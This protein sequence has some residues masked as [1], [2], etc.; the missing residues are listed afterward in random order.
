LGGGLSYANDFA[1]TADYYDQHVRL[2]S[3]WESC[4]GDSIFTVDYDEL[5]DAPEPIL[6]DLLEFLGL[7]WDER[8]LD[9]KRSGGVVKTASLWQVRDGLHKSSSGRWRNYEAF[10]SSSQ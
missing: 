2:M 7:D 6:R 4:F 8:C 3:H 1:N 5:V 9:F 10:I